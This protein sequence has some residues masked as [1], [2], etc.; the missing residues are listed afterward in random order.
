MSKGVVNMKTTG[1]L[2]DGLK[3]TRDL[4]DFMERNEG[5]F[6]DDT[7]SVYLNGLLTEKNLEKSEVIDKSFLDKVYAYQIFSGTKKP[8]RDKLLLLA[9][10]FGLDFDEVQKMLKTCSYP[11]LYAKN[12]RDSIIIYGFMHKLSALKLNFKLDECG[13]R[14]LI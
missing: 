5:E 8:S 2:T 9:L 10:G 12:S 4:N 1:E 14:P 11:Q 7:V 6:K 13:E 3:N